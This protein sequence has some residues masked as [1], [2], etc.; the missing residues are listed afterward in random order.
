MIH[1][2]YFNWPTNQLLVGDSAHATQSLLRAFCRSWVLDMNLFALDFVS[3]WEHWLRL[4]IWT[5]SKISIRVES[6]PCLPNPQR[7]QSQSPLLGHSQNPIQPG[8]T[9]VYQFAGAAAYQAPNEFPQFCWVGT[10]NLL[11]SHW[12]LECLSFKKRKEKEKEKRHL[13][14]EL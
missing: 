1:Q 13:S 8:R 11:V 9:L 7:E 3:K 14:A 12:V 6:S 4:V 5:N 2:F 10:H